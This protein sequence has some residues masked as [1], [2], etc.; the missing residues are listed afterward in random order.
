MKSP[1]SDILEREGAVASQS[2][3]KTYCETVE[4]M[5]AAICYPKDI[6]PLILGEVVVGGD[7]IEATASF[8]GIDEL[9]VKKV[10]AGMLDPVWA[11]VYER[12]IFPLEI[13]YQDTDEEPKDTDDYNYLFYDPFTDYYKIGRSIN[14]VERLSSVNR[15]IPP[16]RQKVEIVHYFWTD[17]SCDSEMEL[18]DLYEDQ[19]LS[20]EWFGLNP[21]DVAYFESINCYNDGKFWIKEDNKE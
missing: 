8:L 16:G 19:R 12:L 10:V 20:G 18:H 21:E 13:A 17:N 5:S 7:A 6:D 11:E 3:W 9:R 1:F 4:E 15:G 14:P 2:V